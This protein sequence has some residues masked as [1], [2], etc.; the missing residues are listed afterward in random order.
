MNAIAATNT[1]PF[2]HAAAHGYPYRRLA[3]DC[4]GCYNDANCMGSNTCYRRV[5]VTQAKLDVYLTPCQWNSPITTLTTCQWV[6]FLGEKKTNTVCNDNACYAKV[7][8]LEWA[9]RPGDDSTPAWEPAP[10]PIWHACTG[11][12]CSSAL[13]RADAGPGT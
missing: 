12:A 4:E 1:P 6:R 8:L 5:I 10:N 13:F 11:H 2:V 7:P 9:L 3:Q